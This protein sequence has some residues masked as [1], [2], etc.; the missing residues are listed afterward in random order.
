MDLSIAAFV[1]V[2]GASIFSPHAAS[3][4]MQDGPV[5]PNEST[6]ALLVSAMLNETRPYGRLPVAEDAP[7]RRVYTI[8]ITAYTSEE[9][10]TDATPCITASGL[11]V[12][13]RDTE[14]IIAANFLPLGTRV[15]MPELF[16]ERVFYVEDRM[17]ERYQYRMDIWMREKQAA[18][19]FGVKRVHVEVF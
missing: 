15:R 12:C 6:V 2:L 5:Y 10:Q 3:A 13:E 7:A 4:D 1:L 18:K 19:Q 8:P 9:G 17:N 14:D 11:N 16:G